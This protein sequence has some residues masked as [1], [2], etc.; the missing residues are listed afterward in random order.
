MISLSLVSEHLQPWLVGVAR[1]H[2]CNDHRRCH[3]SAVGDW[4]SKGSSLA[5]FESCGAQSAVEERLCSCSA[6]YQLTLGTLFNIPMPR[7][8]G[9]E[10]RGDHSRS[11]PNGV[12]RVSD[13]IQEEGLAEGQR[14]ESH[15]LALVACLFKHHSSFRMERWKAILCGP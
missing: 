14:I 13:S 3:L 9:L 10:N 8:L 2:T 4:G 1:V 15:H 7:F 5:G 6:T 12:M 11:L